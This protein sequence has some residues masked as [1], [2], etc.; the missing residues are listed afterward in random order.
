[1]V[2]NKIQILGQNGN[3]FLINSKTSFGNT[4]DNALKMTNMAFTKIKNTI[5]YV[6]DKAE[7]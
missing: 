3:Y 5:C 6:T 4:K 2:T 1:M 7:K